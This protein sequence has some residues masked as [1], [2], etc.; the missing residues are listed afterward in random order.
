MR[1]GG[2]RPAV[3]R[4][5]IL[6]GVASAGLL[7]W[8]FW[9]DVQRVWSDVEAARAWLQSLG[10]WGAMIFIGVNALQ[11]VVAPLPGYATYL[12]AGYVFGPWWGGL[13]ATLGLALGGW[14]AAALA[15]LWGRPLVIRLVGARAWQRWEH[16]V[17]ADSWWLWF[18]ALLAPTGDV[19]F[20]LA[21]LSSLPLWQIVVLGVVV[22]GPAVFVAAAVGAGLVAFSLSTFILILLAVTA[23]TV[24]LYRVGRW[25]QAQLRDASPAP[26]HYHPRDVETTEGGR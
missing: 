16:L 11:I 24:I 7:V 8:W 1:W 3:A 22:R 19:P 14:L 17:H 26:H 6:V 2:V 10:V 23:L 25:A 4:W 9:E 13:Y 12:A 15:R 5:G 20:H 18:L 21:G